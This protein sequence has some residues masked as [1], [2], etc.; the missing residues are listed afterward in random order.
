MKDLEFLHDTS[1]RYQP[2]NNGIAERAVRR[3]KEGTSCVLVQSGLTYEWWRE[4]QDCF[5][6]LFTVVEK[7]TDGFTPYQSRFMRDFEGPLYPFGCEVQYKPASP[8]ELQACHSYGEKSYTHH[9]EKLIL[10]RTVTI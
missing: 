4:A 8:A 3:V 10:R 5:C 1:T 2:Q 6:F 9:K 7:M